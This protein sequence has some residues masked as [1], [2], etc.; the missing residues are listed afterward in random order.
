MSG[1]AELLWDVQAE[2]GEGPVWDDARACLWLVDIKGRRLHRYDPADGAK[3]SW[4]TPDQTGFAL[5]A[6]DGSL[7]C[8]V[9]G[10]L[11][12]FDPSGASPRMQRK[13][14]LTSSTA[15]LML[16]AAA[17]AR[18][19]LAFRGKKEEAQPVH[20]HPPPTAAGRIRQSQAKIR[21]MIR[22]APSGMTK[23]R[24][25]S[26]SLASCRTPVTSTR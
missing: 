3:R 7:V 14:A 23:N 9:R 21:S 1:G 5:P 17:A 18:A 4:D 6:E 15:H 12:R 13:P 10:G 8:G 11:H 24:P 26:P 16:K 25:F 19:Y 2:L 20:R 22:A